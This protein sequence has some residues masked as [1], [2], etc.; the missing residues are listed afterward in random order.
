MSTATEK[1][2]ETKPDDLDRRLRIL[3]VDPAVIVRLCNWRRCG[4]GAYTWLPLVPGLPGDVEF[5]SVRDDFERRQ[6]AF[7]LRH[8]SFDPVPMGEM[9][10]EVLPWKTQFE[11]VELPSLDEIQA[12]LKAKEQE[13]HADD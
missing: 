4:I 9:I 1:P 10:P 11:V 7:T 8:P 5:V 3:R 12:Y 6:L 13:S 2:I